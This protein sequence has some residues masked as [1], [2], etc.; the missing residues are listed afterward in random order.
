TKVS[1]PLPPGLSFLWVPFG[2]VLETTLFPR[3]QRYF[4]W[5]VI[6]LTVIAPF[7]TRRFL[8]NS[9]RAVAVLTFVV[10]PVACYAYMNATSLATA[11][12]KPRVN[13]FEDAH[14][15]VPASEMLRGERLYRDIVPTHGFIEDAAITWIALKARGAT[16]GSAL[17]GRAAVGTL[18][19]V[20]A[21]AVTVAAT[22]VTEAGF[23]AF[24]L[25]T[26]L[27]VLPASVRVVPALFALAAI[28]ASVRMR[29]VRAMYAG[30]FLT[31]LALMTS[32]DF[33]TYTLLTL[34]VS[35]L[36]YGRNRWSAI[37]NAAIGS[38]AAGLPFAAVLAAFGVL[39]DFFRVTLFELPAAATTG[40]LN[41]FTPPQGFVQ[42]PHVPEVLAAIFTKP[43]VTYVS[44]IMAVILTGTL[45]ARRVDRGTLPLLVVS[46]WM[47]VAGLSYAQRHH[48]FF[49]FATATLFVMIAWLVIRRVPALT[50]AIVV[51]LLM[52]A[53]PTTHLAIAA[54]I[55]RTRGPIEQGWTEI[56]ELPRARGALFTVHDA[57]VVRA[58]SRYVEERLPGDNTFFDFTD[59]G[60]LYFLL[61]RDCPV[62][63]IAVPFYETEELQRQVIARIDA[64]PNVRA[65][66]VPASGEGGSVDNIPNQIRAPLVWKYVAEHFTPDHA[67]D[68]VAFWRRRQ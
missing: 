12:G 8:R 3:D 66:L 33:G 28:A 19:S 11:E 41:V 56:R 45:I 38:A 32:L 17:R 63:Q 6:A 40:T 30:G 51:A 16:I 24:L 10:Y 1:S 37:R 55:R 14:H 46:F 53:Q 60:S 50:P 7:I 20:G 23:L 67:E 52:M 47:T 13:F 4:G 39:D 58:A 5:H 18:I 15:L 27:G 31:V 43:A 57:A 36:R 22:G 25:A 44:W 21:Y 26:T 64:N 29:N 65:A 49:E 35:L 34:I 68:D 48:V 2:L 54:W 42:Y 59:R 61:R 9:R 62:R